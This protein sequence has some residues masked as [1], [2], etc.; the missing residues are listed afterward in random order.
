MLTWAYLNEALYLI[1]MSPSF[2]CTQTSINN[3][4][5]NYNNKSLPK[6]T[7]HNINK[8]VTW[9]MT[10][11]PRLDTFCT[12]FI[13]RVRPR[14]SKENVH[15]K[16]QNI[17]IIGLTPRFCHSKQRRHPQSKWRRSS[18]TSKPRPTEGT[19]NALCQLSDTKRKL[20]Q[21]KLHHF[22]VYNKD[23]G[24]VTRQRHSHTYR[25]TVI[26]TTG[27]SLS[28][29]TATHDV[30]V[31]ERRSGQLVW[32]RGWSQHSTAGTCDLSIISPAQYYIDEEKNTNTGNPKLQW[33][34]DV[35]YLVSIIR[36]LIVNSRS[37]LSA[38]DQDGCQ[39]CVK[40]SLTYHLVYVQT[41]PRCLTL[42][43][44][45]ELVIRSYQCP[46]RE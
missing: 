37:Q 13:S 24:T 31:M 25:F 22:Y 15:G 16:M 12:L 42:L 7:L 45:G 35:C 2:S 26:T 40:H 38:A 46:G 14:P 8:E 33:L 17:S 11:I 36:S 9:S 39:S 44:S 32:Q 6:T 30:S 5:G 43:L 27:K 21:K 20:H 10:F 1:P 19:R 23:K 3:K 41:T 29:C 34:E 28:V 4:H 18:L